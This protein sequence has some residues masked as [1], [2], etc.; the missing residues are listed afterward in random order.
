M[1]DFECRDQTAIT[2]E[3]KHD[4]K[5]MWNPFGDIHKDWI[6][7][8]SRWGSAK[9][10]MFYV[11]LWV[12]IGLNGYRIYEPLSFGW[13]CL[14]NDNQSKAT[15]EWITLLIRQYSVF[16]CAWGLVLVQSKSKLQSLQMLFIT[17]VASLAIL[18]VNMES[19]PNS[20]CFARINA[21]WPLTVGWPFITLLCGY[22][23]DR[24]AESKANGDDSDGIEY[25]TG[26]GGGGRGGRN[27]NT[28]QKKRIVKPKRN[29]GGGASGGSDSSLADSV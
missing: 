29:G 5:I 6:H 13:N 4:S 16:V 1:I 20:T 10:I 2:R 12:A 18:W 8:K 7:T 11:Y 9:V 28:N 19:A 27:G 25:N 15:Q 22:V 17:G 23:E 14:T 24:I 3:K 26:G 21:T